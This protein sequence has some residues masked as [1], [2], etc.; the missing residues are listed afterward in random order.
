[1]Q[2]GPSAIPAVCTFIAFI[3]GM[4][5]LFAGSQKGILDGSADI[6]TVRDSLPVNICMR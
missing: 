5:C 2:L 6:L 4:L 3:L 1:M